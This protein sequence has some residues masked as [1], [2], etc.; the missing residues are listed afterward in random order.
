MALTGSPPDR[1]AALRKLLAEAVKLHGEERYDEALALLASDKAA[2]KSATGQNLAG[3]ILLKRDKPR[4]ALKAFEAAVRAAPA[5]AEPHANRSAA[6]QA[7]GRFD[8]AL[9]AA[10]KALRLRPDYAAAH[11][12]RGNALK[13][14]GRAA[15][16]V[17]AYDRAIALRA[18][19]AEAYVNRGSAHLELKLPHEALEDFSAAVKLK[20]RYVAAHIG[21]ASAL[22]ELR[23]FDE[24]LRA[25][26]AAAAIEPDSRE[27]AHARAAILVNTGRA[28]DALALLDAII[29]RA[30]AKAG[31]HTARAIVLSALQRPQEA[32]QA[33]E[34]AVRLDPTNP[35]AY[36]ALGKVL[37]ELGRSEASAA[38]LTQAR[39]YGADDAEYFH[40]LALA[41]MDSDPE[42]ALAAFEETFARDADNV[43][44]HNNRA[45]L[46]IAIGAWPEGWQEHEWRL[47]KPE[48]AGDPQPTLPY[49]RGEDVAGKRLF[50]FAEQGLGDTLQFVRYVRVLEER[51]AHLVLSVPTAIR[52]FLA[53]NFPG[54][55]VVDSTGQFKAFDYRVSLMS[56]PAVMGT[57]LQSVPNTVPYLTADPT[58]VAKWRQRIG[59]EGFRVG[60]VWQGNAK[61][62]RD[63]ERSIRL[64]EYAPLAAVPGVR[65]I[66]LQSAG[67]G[68]DQ[69]KSPPPGMRIEQLGEEIVSNPDGFREVAA[70]MMNLDLLIMSDTGP[71]HLAGALGRPVWL[72]LPRYADW[73]WMREREDT[74][75]YPTMRLFR[76]TTAGDWHGVFDRMAA[77]LAKLA[78]GAAA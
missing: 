10:D 26:D 67:A 16:A 46:R 17:A 72:A 21:R 35:H 78:A 28:G 2:E 71:T 70:A 27:A 18:G 56:L 60:L 62:P 58:R 63:R 55:D 5:A 34:T 1:A 59:E 64:G 23:L 77:E 9:A 69:L 6:L 19:F 48:R 37:A 24:A 41:R 36:V 13:A 14:L 57:T 30:D 20:S 7:L 44:A 50:V 40:A 75:W 12:N 22:G 52:V 76:Q 11:F 51:G 4:E 8:E 66:S 39:R 29:A 32:L 43:L 38:A 65:F 74:P 68:A 54:I 25:V 49:W 45:Y 15:D 3:D 31:D 61:Y 73:R 47:R 33:A 53:D 42:A